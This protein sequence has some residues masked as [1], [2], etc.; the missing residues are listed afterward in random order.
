MIKKEVIYGIDGDQYTAYRPD[1]DNLQES[2]CGFGNT[3]EEALADLERQ[4]K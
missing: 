4:E 2:P 1:F 3:C